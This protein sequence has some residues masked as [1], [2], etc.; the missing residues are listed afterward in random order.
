MPEDRSSSVEYVLL[1]ENDAL[2]R[3]IRQLESLLGTIQ[4]IDASTQ[5][6]PLPGGQWC[7]EAKDT[8]VA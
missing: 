1:H 6:V 5:T 2:R 4:P 7:V 8:S 3:R